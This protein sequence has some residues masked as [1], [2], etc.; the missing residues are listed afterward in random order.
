MHSPA[1]YGQVVHH[2]HHKD[3]R[4]RAA[5][6][7]CGRGKER[8]PRHDRQV[9]E[10]F[11]ELEGVARRRLRRVNGTLLTFFICSASDGPR[12]APQT[13]LLAGAAPACPGPAASLAAFSNIFNRSANDMNRRPT[14]RAPPLLPAS[15]SFAPAGACSRD[16][17]PSHGSADALAAPWQDTRSN[18]YARVTKIPFRPTNSQA[19]D[20]QKFVVACSERRATPEQRQGTEGADARDR[21]PA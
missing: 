3:T 7:K 12:A 18:S 4:R 2:V 19:C 5:R 14:T 17:V 1:P 8:V 6:G 15:G 9:R 11:D 10:V 20:T 21:R 13:G 16:S